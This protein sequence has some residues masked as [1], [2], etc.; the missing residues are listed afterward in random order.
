LP[1]P[2]SLRLLPTLLA[3]VSAY[4]LLRRHWPLP[5]VLAISAITTAAIAAF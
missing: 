4:L 1:D 5:L 2:S 3:G